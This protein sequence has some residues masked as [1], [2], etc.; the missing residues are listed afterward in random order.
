MRGGA[1][2][3]DRCQSSDYAMMQP[4]SFWCTVESENMGTKRPMVL[5]MVSDQFSEVST[6]FY[7]V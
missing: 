2:V 3:I 7:F 4:V 5:R 1:G 6:R